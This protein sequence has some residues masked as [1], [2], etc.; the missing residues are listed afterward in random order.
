MGK[1]LL[2]VL[3]VIASS[4]FCITAL[5]ATA[6]AYDAADDEDASEF[7]EAEPESEATTDE[8][9][10]FLS[11]NEESARAFTYN[12]EQITLYKAN[13]NIDINND[14]R[15]NA[16]DARGLLRVS[17]KLDPLELDI[18]MCDI[19]GDGSITS[20]DARLLLRYNA[21]VDVYYVDE[22]SKAVSGWVTDEDSDPCYFTEN[23]ILASGYTN[24]DG[25]YY[26]FANGGT[27]KD[28]K[29]C[30]GELRTQGKVYYFDE[31]GV[32]ISEFKTI[33]NETYYFADGLAQTGLATI[34]GTVYG[35]SDSGVMLNGLNKIKNS[36]YYFSGGKAQ[37]GWITDNGSK[38]YFG[39]DFTAAT[40]LVKIDGVTYGF[41]DSGA[42]YN[43]LA[44]IGSHYYC[45]SDGK[46]RTGWITDNGNKYY[47]GSDFTAVTGSRT[48]DGKVYVF[49]D[50]GILCNGYI[51]KNGNTYYYVNGTPYSG[52]LY[53][54]LNSYYFYSDGKMAKNTT[55]GNASFNSSG[56]ASCNK[57]AADTLQV[58]IRDILKSTGTST[59]AIYNYVHYN[60]KY[61]YF[62]KSTPDQMVLRILQ[63][64][65]GAC[66]DFANLTK[67][68]LEAAGYECYIVVGD[69]F[70]PNNG[71]EHDWVLVKVDG[72]WRH[73][74]TQR[75]VYLKTD[76]QMKNLG[77][78]WSAQGLPAAN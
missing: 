67:Y 42:A 75:G 61:K 20:A 65:K 60:Y 17:A 37:T 64:K 38:Y 9:K 16:F 74:D 6:Y 46:A 47:F 40:G 30:Y 43:G 68:L 34:D 69:S 55:I 36:T 18:E 11:I 41:S 59:S 62:T 45:F 7:I 19:S 77:Y 23:G 53:D 57:L 21:R 56:I 39:S 8:Y 44:K 12:G 76:A 35:F 48:I 63:N 5:N 66:Y 22:S 32:G 72:V 70:N 49:S 28:G 58:Y 73:M 51:N 25:S 31:N 33:G 13:V 10:S 52:W 15:T 4:L 54:G 71:N 24:V 2:R 3:F 1:S 29:I 26:Y 50:S 78:G 27:E 14:G